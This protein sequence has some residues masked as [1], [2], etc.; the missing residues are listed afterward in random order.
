MP[1]APIYRE[2]VSTPPLWWVL[3]VL[4]AVSCGAAVGFYLGLAWGLGVGSAALL[5][6]MAVLISAETVITVESSCVRVGRAMIELPYVGG[7]R[8]LNAAETA[9][10]SGPE[11]D[12]RAYLVLRPYVRTAVELAVDDAADPVPYWLISTRRPVALARAVEDARAASGAS[13]NTRLTK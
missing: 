9:R 1:A 5:L 4:L 2:R 13:P 3:A 11:A 10:R 12:A 7:C 6:T 8:A